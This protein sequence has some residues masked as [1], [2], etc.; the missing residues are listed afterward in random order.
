MVFA[1][2]VSMHHEAESGLCEVALGAVEE[3]AG[4]GGDA[5]ACDGH[6]IEDSL[7][8]GVALSIVGRQR[9]LQDT[10]VREI[11]ESIDL[12]HL[13]RYRRTRF[14]L[15]ALGR[16]LAGCR[17]EV[18]TFLNNLKNNSDLAQRMKIFSY[19]CNV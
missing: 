18:G 3:L 10:R 5:V 15:R 11:R 4:V 1:V 8:Q 19:L 6:G 16:T 2:P 13:R 17:V 9:H 7:A 14:R 12:I